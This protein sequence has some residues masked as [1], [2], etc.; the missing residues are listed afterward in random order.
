[1]LVST[2]RARS[3]THN[4]AVILEVGRIALLC[5]DFSA[6]LLPRCAQ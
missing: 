1:L 4:P 6:A 3:R 2:I 5:L